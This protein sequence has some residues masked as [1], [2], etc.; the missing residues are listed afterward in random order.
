[1]VINNKRVMPVYKFAASLDTSQFNPKQRKENK[2]FSFSTARANIGQR[3]I[4]MTK[5]SSKKMFVLIWYNWFL[6][7]CVTSRDGM[8]CLSLIA[9]FIGKSILGLVVA[10]VK[11]FVL[12]W[13]DWFLCHCVTSGLVGLFVFCCFFRFILVCGFVRFLLLCHG[14]H[15]ITISSSPVL[16]LITLLN[17]INLICAN[18]YFIRWWRYLL[19][20]PYRQKIIVFCWMYS[21]EFS[22]EMFCLHWRLHS[23]TILWISRMNS[24]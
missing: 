8:V 22:K 1:M 6:C 11:M 14:L 24:S 23:S 13:Y 5:I 16:S 18:C 9:G 4:P 17:K 15:L 12:V 3:K 21:L 2:H 7:H 10:V 19:S 20:W